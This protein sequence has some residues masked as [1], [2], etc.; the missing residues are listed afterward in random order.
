MKYEK[1]VR[2]KIPERLDKKGISYEKRVA[3]D[4]EYRSELI[5]KLVEEA[6][7]YRDSN[8][9]VDELADVLEVIN[10]IKKLPEYEGI[11]GIRQKKVEERGAFDKKLILKGE[12]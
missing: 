9:S 6:E 10:A 11:E 5:K 4:D 12:K 8:G 3:T 7:E 1:L 2:D